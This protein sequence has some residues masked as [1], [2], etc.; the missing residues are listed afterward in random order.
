V[1][2]SIVNCFANDHKLGLVGGHDKPLKSVSFF[3]SIVVT[4]VSHWQRMTRPVNNWISPHN[5]HGCLLALSRDFANNIKLP[6]NLPG[7]DLF[8]F[9]ENMNLGFNFE[10]CKDAIVYFKT[11]ANLKDFVNQSVRFSKSGNYINSYFPH[12]RYNFNMKFV[13]KVKSYAISL[14][15]EPIRFPI[16]LMLQF[17]IA[18]YTMANNKTYASGAWA[19]IKSSK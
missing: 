15:T 13:D 14:F 9:Y 1:F 11:P 4:W 6:E 2:E 19:T 12:L 17:V 10:F 5:S 3:Q 16:A 8:I 18:V 7:N